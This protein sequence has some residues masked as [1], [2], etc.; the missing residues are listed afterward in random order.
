MRT[1]PVGPVLPKDVY[2]VGGIDAMSCSSLQ[3]SPTK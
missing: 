1:E 2:M 3:S